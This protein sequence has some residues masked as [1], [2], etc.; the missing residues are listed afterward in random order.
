MI[1]AQGRYRAGE[2]E[3]RGKWFDRS[4]RDEV[5]VLITLSEGEAV[6]PAMTTR[7]VSF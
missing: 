4:R 1:A 3:N 5:E 6:P 7:N 2:Q